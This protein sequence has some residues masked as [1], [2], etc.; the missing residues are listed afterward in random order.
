MEGF[1]K[2]IFYGGVTIVC[3]GI[4]VAGLY[5]LYHRGV[6]YHLTSRSIEFTHPEDSSKNWSKKFWV[7]SITKG[8]GKDNIDQNLQELCDLEDAKIQVYCK[9]CGAKQDDMVFRKK[10]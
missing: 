8:P 9:G 10:D 6:R 5:S 7:F 4:W 1:A 3:G 2:N